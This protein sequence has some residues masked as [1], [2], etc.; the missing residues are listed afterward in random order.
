MEKFAFKVYS[1]KEVEPISMEDIRGGAGDDK[2][3]CEK[4]TACNVNLGDEDNDED[5][6]PIPG[7]KS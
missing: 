5:S 2:K 1:L 6:L 4:N 3:C 7:Q